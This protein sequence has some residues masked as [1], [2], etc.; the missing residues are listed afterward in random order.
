MANEM[1]TKSDGTKIPISEMHNGYLINAYKL[2]KRK[3]AIRKELGTNWVDKL[4][5]TEIHLRS[6]L[7]K[8]GL[9]I[10]TDFSKPSKPV[11]HKPFISQRVKPS[12]F[13]PKKNNIPNLL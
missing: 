1:W 7:T 10:P 5:S 8:R 11:V 2:T 13:K 9:D 12:L 3:L 4:D 6:E